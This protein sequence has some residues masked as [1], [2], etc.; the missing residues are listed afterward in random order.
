MVKKDLSNPAASLVTA[1]ELRYIYK[2]RDKVLPDGSILQDHV[3][4]WKDGKKV[5]PPWIS[6]PD[7]W[8]AQNFKSLR[9]K[10]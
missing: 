2:N 5:D 3:Q 1:K 7:L 10:R 8:N 9:L 4:F 6:H